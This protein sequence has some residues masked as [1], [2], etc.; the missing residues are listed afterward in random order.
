M[1]YSFTKP[2]SKHVLKPATKAWIFYFILAFCVLVGFKIKLGLQIE[3]LQATQ[4]R[5]KAE[6]E[7]I[8]AKTDSLVKQGERLHYELGVTTAIKDHDEKLRQQIQNI[9]DMI[10]E[11][12]AI[13]EIKFENNRL[14]MRGITASK[15]LFETSLQSQLRAIYTTSNATFYELPS[16]WY[17]F[18]SVSITDDANAL[19]NRIGGMKSNF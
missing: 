18:E 2:T 1:T 11:K 15:E 7:S 13:H 4:Q 8:V 17:N 16:G 3:E 14:F 6:Q 12:V 10:P 5:L 19:D 9:L